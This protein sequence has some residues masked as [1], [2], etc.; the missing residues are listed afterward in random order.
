M[1]P[2]LRI[3]GCILLVT[4]I[5]V[6]SCKKEY[7]CENCG[8][9]SPGNTNRSPIAN[10]GSDQVITLPTDSVSLDGSASSDPDGTISSFQWTKI[11]GSVS[12][13]IANAATAGTLVKNLAAGAYQFELKVTDNG[14]LSAKD[15]IQIIV[16]DPGQPNRPPVANA[17]P[18]QNITL[19][20]NTVTLN[21][22][23]STDPDNNITNYYWTKISGPGSINIINANAVQTQVTNLVQGTYQFELKVT[24]AGGLI[25]KDTLEV[26]VNAALPPTCNTG[27]R[28]LINAQLVPFGT[29]SQSRVSLTVASAGNKIFFAGG[30]YN[31]PGSPAASSRVDIYDLI[32]NT[33]T[34]AELSQAR[35]GISSAVLGNKIFFAGGYKD[36]NRTSSAVDIYDVVTNTWTV[37]NLSVNRAEIA[38]GTV[39]N[40]VVFAGGVHAEDGYWSGGSVFSDRVDIYDASLNTWTVAALSEKMRVG[41]A[42]TTVGNRI[43]FAGGTGNWSIF[44]YNPTSKIDIYDAGTNTWS[45][46][47]LNRARGGLAGIAVNNKIYWAGGEVYENLPENINQVEIKDINAQTSSLECLFQPNAFFSAVAK[48]NKIVFFTGWGVAQNKFDIYDVTTSSWSIGVLNQNIYDAAIISVNNTIYVAGGEVNGVLSNQVWKLEF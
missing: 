19:P 16:N 17:G 18:D 20:T 28:M 6:S 48:S 3:V 36:G 43:Y 39:G 30:N 40:K 35:Y 46:S 15:T 22:N 25:S 44:D 42:V 41:M 29:L 10:A 33:W 23:G 13:I 31:I 26:N 2:I 38:A 12:F 7:S 14:G 4:A 27:N 37:A 8:I 47:A 32:S 1:K 9:N 34:T 24:D 45:T 11:S 5:A 21:G